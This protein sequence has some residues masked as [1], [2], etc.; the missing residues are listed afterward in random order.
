MR[1][2]MMG[3]G[4]FAVP[5]LRWLAASPHDVLALVTRDASSAA[6]GRSKTSFNPMAAAAEELGITIDRVTDANQPEV[7]AS[8]RS[9][10]PELLAVC[11]FGTILSQDILGIARLGAINLHGSL[12]PKYRG[13]APVQWALYHGERETGVTVIHLTPRLDAGPI[14]VQRATPIGP[15]E[16][17]VVLEARLAEM[18][19]RCVAEAIE[20]LAVWN[21][22]SPIGRPQDE[23]LAT[24]APRLKKSHGR[25][26]WSQ[27]AEQIE[28]QVRAFKPW[29]GST[30]WW[31]RK[32][33]QWLPLL[34]E[35]ARVPRHVVRTDVAPGT[36]TSVDEGVI[37]VAT[38][39]GS[40]EIVVLKPAGKRSMSADEFLRGYRLEPGT[41]LGRPT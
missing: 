1:I 18:G 20:Q 26:D 27:S 30:T 29:P 8:V 6:N 36:V 13:A 12:L 41:R 25:I 10:Q 14:L 24:R 15:S 17:A 16:D 34:V 21:G 19:P 23:T 9:R 22:T 5:T 3:T 4:P 31:Q 37:R 32:P 40:L 7:V 35:T 11:D 39:N 38:G 33:N 28:R 2:V